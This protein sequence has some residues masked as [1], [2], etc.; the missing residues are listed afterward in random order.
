MAKVID[1]LFSE[2][3]TGIDDFDFGTTTAEVFDDMLE[4]SIPLSRELQRMTGELLPWRYQL[5][6]RRD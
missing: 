6:D 2:Q 1:Q 5:R 3:Q 4:R